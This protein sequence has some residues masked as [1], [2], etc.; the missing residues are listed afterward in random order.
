[1]SEQEIR[2]LQADLDLS[3]RQIDLLMAID[4]IRDTEPEPGAML[5]AIA[6]LL[7]DRLEA[8]LCLM[9]LL[10]PATGVAEL[11]AFS[12]RAQGAELLRRGVTPELVREIVALD[13]VT[14]WMG[15]EKLPMA[16]EGGPE[17]LY[18][19]AVPIIMGTHERLGALL[20]ARF[21]KP[22]GPNEVQL[23][24]TAEDLIDSAVVQGFVYRR[25]QQTVRE[26]GL[27]RR[28][29][30]L[31]AAID[32]IRDAAPEPEIMLVRIVDL[33]KEQLQADLCLMFLLDQGANQARLMAAS[34]QG[35]EETR[36]RPFITQ[37][38]VEE[39]VGLDDV[40]IWEGREKL[41]AEAT[42]QVPEQTQ[43]AAVPIIMGTDERLGALLLVRSRNPFGPDDLQLL[44]TAEDQID[45]AV[46]QGYVQQRHRRALQEID[47]RKKELDL[48]TAIDG[49]RDAVTEPAAM[50]AS[51][52]DLLAERLEADFCAIFLLDPEATR[53][54]LKAVSQRD[55][56]LDRLGRFV[57]R[58]LA[59]E[60]AGL[61]EVAIWEAH[62]KLSTETGIDAPE[63]LQ[64]AAVPI[65]I[66]ADKRLGA[67]LLARARTPFG[68]ADVQLLK[69]AEDQIDSA[70][71]QGYLHNRHQLSVKEIET[72]YQ[73]DLIRDQDLSLD[74]ML[75]QVLQVLTEKISAEMGFV[76]L[77]DRAGKQL[78]RRAT[79]HED[80][81]R[82]WGY[83]E[84][85]ERVVDEALESGDL[86]C[87][88]NLTGELRSV[89]CLPLILNE[90]IIGVLGVVNHYGPQGFLAADCRLLRAIG[91]Q[92]DTAIYERREIRHMRRVL[93][94]SID[95][96]VME[97]LLTSPDVDILR[98]ERLELTV[99]YADMRGSTPLAEKTDPELL[100]EFIKDYLTQMTQ[101]VLSHEGTVDKFIGDEVMALFG[102]PIPQEDH[103]LRAV[104]VGLEMQ[105]VYENLMA[106]WR[107][108]GVD[109]PPI[110]VG[111]VTGK[112][113][114]GEMG[115]PQRSDY[116]VLGRDVNLGA[117]ICG[118]ARGGQV[119]IS[120]P[121]YDLVKDW[122]EAT[123]LPGQQFK[124]V[125]Q[126]VTVYRIARVLDGR[127]A[128]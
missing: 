40:T 19:A 69:T 71:V 9:F 66:G 25:H 56:R 11:E 3:Q 87:R 24:R 73:V 58:E 114:V 53:V 23:L 106:D 125:A 82:I 117:R 89:M 76:M 72:I 32:E 95:P 60:A 20:L 80:L 4:E 55:H 102:A 52:V 21:Q 86:I 81:F 31:I 70:V 68:P 15:S 47:L 124:G 61:D 108:R 121:T 63:G 26:V 7:A 103:A 27:R 79:T 45:S 34:D 75:N 94:R 122:V 49:I 123:S 96:R 100:V 77:Y 104:R 38:L 120:E 112:M 46:I 54:E 50:L 99:L 44:R 57:T 85:V 115:S 116:T 48:I 67:L 126:D 88:N 22:F 118:V 35:Q 92:I 109:A 64:L 33:L 84:I 127:R 59:A 78:E 28:E 119:L 2:T 113:I 65:I 111:I 1:M 83:C 90:Q 51:I 128:P 13:N 105:A 74:E 10:N 110:G 97:R 6:N 36:F 14:L 17:E 42:D 91:S 39:A 37:E 16:V 107:K 12:E 93:G 5:A 29:L 62:E 41:P 8:A 18:L 101:I 98:P 30:A 43:L